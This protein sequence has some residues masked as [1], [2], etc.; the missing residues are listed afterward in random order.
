MRQEASPAA[1]IKTGCCL[2]PLY[3]QMS[4]RGSGFD[5]NKLK[6]LFDLLENQ[7][8]FEFVI[9]SSDY[10]VMKT[11]WYLFQAE[12]VKSGLEAKEICLRSMILWRL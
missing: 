5:K 3:L 12:I 4:R 10:G 8:E 9:A 2:K 1:I 6:L 11:N 7:F